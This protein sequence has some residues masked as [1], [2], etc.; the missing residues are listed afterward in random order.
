MSTL[1]KMSV[2]TLSEFL[3]DRIKEREDFA[4]AATQS[5]KWWHWP[6]NGPYP[7]GEGCVRTHKG[8]YI[9]RS[10]LT[11]EDARHIATWDPSYV[12][13][14]CKAE[15]KIIKA[16]K[17]VKYTNARLNIF[18]ADVCF[19]CHNI[20]DEPED[21]DEETNGAWTYPSIQAYYPCT[22]LKALG[23]VYKGWHPKYRKEWA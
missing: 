17:C 15:R 20:L 5:V 3:L 11:W 10:T 6:E 7:Y 19:S 22:T 21:W 9:C 18:A 4:R 23:H 8:L 16:H 2:M 13:A 14:V 1:A 12:L